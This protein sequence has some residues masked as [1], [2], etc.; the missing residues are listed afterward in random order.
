MTT[1]R[2]CPQ[3]GAANLPTETVCHACQHPLDAPMTLPHSLLH[4]RYQVLDVVGSGGFG[5]VYRARDTQQ[6]DCL[7]ALK[8]IT[9]TGLS[10]QEIIE[11]TDG[12]NREAQIL[13]T[14]SHPRLP[15]LL[16]RFNDPA[17][18]YLVLTF[19]D[20]STLDDYLQHHAVH[21][22]L[23]LEETL[24][25]GLQLGEVLHYLHTRQPPVIFRDLKP[26]NIMRSPHGQ[27]SLIDFGIARHFK[28]G[29]RKDTMPFGSPGF[30]APEQYGR[31]QTTQQ[32]DIYSL[33][34]LLHCLLSGDDPADHPFQFPPLRLPGGEG[35]QEMDALIQRMVALDPPA[36]PASIQHVQ[37]AFERIQRLHAQSSAPHIWIPPQGQAPP[38]PSTF[39]QQHLFANALATRKTSR[40]RVVTASLLVGG[41]VLIG[42][43]ATALASNQNNAVNDASPAQSQ[44]PP[45]SP[46]D[47]TAT[48]QSDSAT[49]TAIDQQAVI[50][51]DNPSFWSPDLSR[52]LVANFPQG[53]ASIYDVKGRQVIQVLKPFPTDS[54]TQVLWSPN[55]DRIYLVSNTNDA[56]LWD[57]Q[58]GNQVF[59]FPQHINTLISNDQMAQAAWSPD[60]KYLAIGYA[61]LDTSSTVTFAL[62]DTSTGSKLY[63]QTFQGLATTAL[64][65]SP[66][67]R[68]VAF[69]DF[70]A[71]AIS[72]AWS[73]IIWDV[74]TRQK[75]TS[76][77]GSVGGIEET[78][79]EVWNL[80]WSPRSNKIAC[81]VNGGL[82]TGQFGLSL[83]SPLTASSIGAYIGY[84]PAAMF[85]W[86]PNEYYLTTL[87]SEQISV[88]NA[89]NGQFVPAGDGS[90]GS[91]PNIAAFAWAAD[92]QHISVVDTNNVIS[93]WSVG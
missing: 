80:A 88:W 45:F 22:A 14:L 11:A 59:T 25:I 62:L 6:H 30:A 89:T 16:D 77:T 41:A 24:T 52:V 29:Q 4:D 60:G 65:W 50:P 67:S 8:Q 17:H 92:S 84:G 43:I 28:P 87:T 42:G 86:S 72:A 61:P 34:A 18:W 33:G 47:A 36:R 23:S 31:A 9:L 27:L 51:S 44:P 78:E 12:F 75:V 13:S 85:L 20:G 81:I 58:R 37:A 55:N 79:L 26:S 91:P 3:C 69:P 35:G 40:R 19:L 39:A 57:I 32:T 68:Y 38:A 83:S 73:I 70:D 71:R 53:E 54:S 76:L 2:F 48:A 46:D 1:S 7:V 56:Q 10:P 63:E 5:A 66:D 93:Q 64:A 74:V 21:H 90:Y 49:A 82:W 15:R